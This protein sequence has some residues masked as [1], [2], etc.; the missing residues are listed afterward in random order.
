MIGTVRL[1]KPSPPSFRKRMSP[2][3]VLGPEEKC[4]GDPLRRTGNEY[5]YQELAQGNVELLK[6][7]NV[8]K[9]VTA[10]PHCFNTLK[11][12]YPAAGWLPSRSTITPSL[13]RGLP[14]KAR[15]PSRLHST[16]PPPTMTPA[17]SAGSTV[18]STHRGVSQQSL[19]KGALWSWAAIKTKASAA[20]AGAAGSGWKSTIS[21]S[22]MPASMRPSPHRANT[23]ITACP[24]CLIM[25][26]DAIKDKAQSET[27]KALDISEVVAKG[28]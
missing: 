4:C 10:C 27:M 8:K 16:A 14:R 2:S 23:V 18:N 6:E 28:L 19:P 1:P 26:E 22:T 12:D 25:M 5:Q 13:S 24:Y 3:A 9:I 15:S 11:N 7:L 17:I 21:A 20:V